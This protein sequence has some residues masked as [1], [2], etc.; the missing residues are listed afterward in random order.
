[1]LQ[2]S[3]AETAELIKMPFGMWIGGGPR[4]H[5]SD[6]AQIPPKGRATFEGDMPS[7]QYT[8]NDSQKAVHN[9]AVCTSPL[10][11]PSANK[12]LVTLSVQ[13]CG[14]AV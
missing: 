8:Q 12:D 6:G 9:D 13:F 7:S 5:V 10:L 4:N 3:P 11:W 14:L 1:L 2:T